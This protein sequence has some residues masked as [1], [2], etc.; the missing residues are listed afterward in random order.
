MW[1]ETMKK[2]VS[3]YRLYYPVPHKIQYTFVLFKQNRLILCFMF[4]LFYRFI[5]NMWDWKQAHSNYLVI[6]DTEIEE[7]IDNVEGQMAKTL[8]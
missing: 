6:S 3:S 5:L 2:L 1:V 4:L 7:S 8:I